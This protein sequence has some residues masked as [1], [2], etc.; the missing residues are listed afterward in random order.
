ME[1]QI[2]AR[3]NNTVLQQAA[4]SYGTAANLL[5]ELD[6]FENFIYEFKRD[7]GEYILRIAHR[8]RRSEALIQGEVAWINYLAER[9]TPVARAVLS[10]N[11]KLV[12]AIDDGHGEYFL[13][14][15]FVKANGKPPWEVDETPDLFVDY[16]GE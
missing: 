12:E 8:S 9:G 13:A 3:L 15:A 2:R 5:E 16:Y 14:T 7:S 6:G 11:G 1:Q 10:E 4:Q